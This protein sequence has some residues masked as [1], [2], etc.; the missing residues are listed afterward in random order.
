M[1]GTCPPMNANRSPIPRAHRTKSEVADF[2]R[3]GDVPS[4]SS[5]R[6]PGCRMRFVRFRTS[7]MASPDTIARTRR[8]LRPAPSSR[9]LPKRILAKVRKRE[10]GSAERAM[11]DDEFGSVAIPGRLL[12]RPR[13]SRRWERRSSFR[14]RWVVSTRE[15]ST[16]RSQRSRV[17]RS[18]AGGLRRAARWS[19]MA[20]DG[21]R[22]PPPTLER[23]EERQPRI[24]RQ[25][26]S[27]RSQQ[28]TDKQLTKKEKKRLTFGFFLHLRCS[29]EVS[30]G[31]SRGPGGIRSSRHPERRGQRAGRSTRAWP[32]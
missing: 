3:L 32:W 31:G 26:R 12:S 2:A 20:R 16:R 25:N 1:V 18:I 13:G 8:R 23:D 10:S 28:T 17:P 27:P 19:A 15:E 14:S 5:Q 6:D 29:V 11:D 22:R 7:G 4:R 9:P 30:R 24:P 21:A